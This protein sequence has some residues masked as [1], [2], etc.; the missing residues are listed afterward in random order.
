M[1]SEPLGDSRLDADTIICA[2]HWTD[3]LEHCLD[4]LAGRGRTLVIVP[5]QLAPEEDTGISYRFFPVYAAPWSEVRRLGQLRCREALLVLPAERDHE[6]LRLCAAFCAIAADQHLR[7]HDG[8]IQRWPRL[9]LGLLLW[10]KLRLRIQE[11]SWRAVMLLAPL[12]FAA[13]AL[14]R[15]W[16]RLRTNASSPGWLAE[17]WAAARSIARH[18]WLPTQSFTTM[19]WRR[20][21]LGSFISSYLQGEEPDPPAQTGDAPAFLVLM[22]DLLGD[23]ISTIPLVLALREAHPRSRIEAVVSPKGHE[24]LRGCPDIDAFHELRE[25]HPFNHA[26]RPFPGHQ[27]AWDEL[28]AR[29]AG[30][31]FDAVIN[32]SF[33]AERAILLNRIPARRRYSVENRNWLLHRCQVDAWNPDWIYRSPLRAAQPLGAAQ[34]PVRCRLWLEPAEAAAMRTRF[35]LGGAVPTIGVAGFAPFSSRRWPLARLAEAMQRTAAARPVRWIIL[36]RPN[37]LWR[38]SPFRDARFAGDLGLREVMAL[39]AGL[40]GLLGNEGGLGHIAGA[41]GI[42]SVLLYTCIDPRIWHPA[43]PHQAL[44]RKVDCS[45]CG[46]AYCRE[47]LQCHAAVGVDEVVAATI[48]MLDRRPAA[49]S[50]P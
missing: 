42:P 3:E 11:S 31:H 41:L 17:A 18:R 25:Y 14:L 4:R 43:G 33:W 22:P 15:L 49:G 21:I 48:A 16:R 37:R 45:P 44:Y 38:R 47:R 8:R 29:F 10:R 36:D 27:R 12:W 50:A 26:S 6:F 46:L 32:A 28:I 9:R 34:E 23:T 13:P 30:R 5:E 7:A 19:R 20:R 35:G 1:S 2:P 24:M 40:D 39:I